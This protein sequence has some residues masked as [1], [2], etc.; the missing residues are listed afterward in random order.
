M[1]KVTAVGMD[2]ITEKSGHVVTPMAPSVCTTPAAPAPLPVPYPV[3]GT[4]AGGI[5]GPTSRTK[6]GGAKIGTVGG[7]F[8]AVHGNEP[9]TL[10]EVVSLTTGGPAP[11]L[12]GAPVV[13]AELGMVGITGSPLLAN[14]GPGPS[15]R[16]A[17]V[18]ATGPASV[19]A[20]ATKGGGHDGG[21]ADGNANGGKDG[22][23]G[24]GSGGGEGG[25]S[26]GKSASAAQEGQEGCNDPID[27]ITGRVYTLPAVDLEL[28][29]P[30]PLVFARV[31]SS[32]AAHR[33]V[34]L[35]F[36]WAH[37]WGWEIEPRFRALVVWS[38][39]G[40]ATDFPQLDVGAEHVGPWGWSLRRERDRLV[41]DTGDGVRRV[42]AAIDESAR[43]WRLIELRDRNDNCTELTYDDRG[44]LV[45]VLDSSGRSVVVE[46]SSAGRIAALHV[47]N[48]IAQGRWVAVARFTYDKAGNLTAATDAEGHAERF[49]YDEEHRLTRK[50]ECEGLVFS[51][52]YDREGRCVEGWGEYPSG[53][54]PSLA[55]DVP[56][57]LA[58]G[59]RARG[60]LHARLD[61][62]LEGITQLTDSTQ[63]RH[64]FGNHHGLVEKR[65]DRGGVEDTTYDDRG[66]VLARMDGEGAVTRYER[67]VRGRV[68]KVT[69]PLGRV[70]RYER[71]ARGLAARIVDSAGGV[72]EIHRDHHGNAIHESDPTGAV[73][74]YTH[75]ARG[76]MTSATSPIGGITRYLHDEAG[77]LAARID[78]NGAR[79][80]WQYDALGR[81][82]LAIDPLGHETRFAWTA[83]GDV[84]AVLRGE[85]ATTRYTYDGE[86]RLVE[87]QGPG[88]RTI[89]LSWGGY[90]RLIEKTGAD[91]TT[92]RYRYNREGELTEIH[93]EPG[94][95]H[96]L[97]RDGAGRVV[98]EETFDGRT[99]TYR[100]DHVGR[101]V[102]AEVSG[103]VT[104][105]AYDAA[106]TLVSRTLPDETIETFEHDVRGALVRA[107]WPGGELRFERDEAGRVKREVQV[108]QGEEHSV[109]SFYDPAG[110]RV[111]RF[112]SCGHVEHVERDAAGE[113]IRTILDERNDVQHERDSLGRETARALPH[114]GRILQDHDALGRVRRRWATSPGKLRRVRA[115]D[116]EWVAGAVPEQPA[117]VTAEHEYR[118]DAA[119]ELSDALDRRRGWVQ[120]EYDP[121]GR[122]L[123]SLREATGEEER[124]RYDAASNLYE[125]DRPE[126]DARM[127]GPGGLL[128]RRDDTVY[129]WDRAGRLAEKRKQAEDGTAEVWRYTWD[130]AGM[131]AAVELPGR[132]RAEYAYDPFGR[133][134]ESRVG[135]LI[136]GALEV[137]ERTRFVWD[138]DTIAH[139][140]RTRA[141]ADGDPVVEERT[142]AFEDG[143]FV[144]WAQCDD[145]PDGFGGRRRT[146]SFFVND[147]IGTPDEIVGGDGALVAALNR[148]AWGR[149]EVLEADRAT[150]PL[151]F[152]GQ[153]EDP[154]TGLFYNRFRYY[155]ADAA[156]YLSPD[157]LGLEGGLRPFGYGNNPVRWVDPLG[158][159]PDPPPPPTPGGNTLPGYNGKKTE[160]WLVRPDGSEQHIRSGY[161]GP[162]AGASIPGMDRNLTA[163]VEGHACVAMRR[164]NLNQATLYI[165]RNP[166][167]YS[168][169]RGGMNGCHRRLPDMLP[170]GAQLTVIGPAGQVQ[171]YTGQPDK[172]GFN[173]KL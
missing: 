167:E 172:H 118:Y 97:L 107:T 88:P 4:S 6:M 86:R 2:V 134:V 51:F 64:Y 132:R 7:G 139:A 104:E 3:S 141:T 113:R 115:D 100:R 83:R 136:S 5:M 146:W 94:E 173:T 148:K 102:R 41:L 58:D 103:D 33:D 63:I 138:G 84:A 18:P 98:E 93:N 150:T 57:T 165:N 144:P 105:H 101:V 11:I 123:S 70:T 133:R 68:V 85:G 48:A 117:R 108:L 142:F 143:S 1:S 69:D 49:V 61:Y 81:C 156:L 129:T 130:G 30:L 147:P 31:Y 140:I 39:D 60:I 66:L 38:D 155:D 99:L 46:T 37:T 24:S 80:R 158:L 114:G 92:V 28:P 109:A 145:G 43:R 14:R 164:E 54:D 13:L 163:H 45:E 154:E 106:G 111:R 74:S 137:Q 27:V 36:G 40:T 71:D 126:G 72:Y 121:A 152:Q 89:G 168:N 166:C 157:P 161:D 34:G 21:D 12:M 47:R 135:V 65:V 96:R 15:G 32:T 91:G 90:G 42:F 25:K 171:T 10:K 151:R 120:Y 82:V 128:L 78:P 62:Q 9:G 119:G 131:L 110:G 159:L 19:P 169:G 125:A 22:K 170:P 20:V 76:L 26:D 8:S 50:T 55:D 87:I 112:T 127:Y 29:G 153:Q 116:P 95:I 67:D 75:D 35:G 59:S 73:R 17:P 23:G 77:N 53:R 149:T 160:G 162:S 122:L 44:H 79:W 56:A 16:T 52:V 124:F